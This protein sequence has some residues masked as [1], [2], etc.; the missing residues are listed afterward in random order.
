MRE[1]GKERMG[2]NR[3]GTRGCGGYDCRLRGSRTTFQ[4]SRARCRELQCCPGSA[5][6]SGSLGRLPGAARLHGGQRRPVSGSWQCGRLDTA[7]VA[8]VAYSYE[9]GGQACMKAGRFSDAGKCFSKAS[10]CRRA[11]E[12]MRRRAAARRTIWGAQSQR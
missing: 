7:T 5:G 4:C 10:T 11:E 6:G 12:D 8:P 9:L 3:K 2:R 1:L